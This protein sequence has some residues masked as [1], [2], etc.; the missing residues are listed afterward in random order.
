MNLI[1]RPST[2]AF[3]CWKV[4]EIMANRVSWDPRDIILKQNIPETL[5]NIF[6]MLFF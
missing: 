3:A 2:R 1:V 6:Y 5:E 4:S